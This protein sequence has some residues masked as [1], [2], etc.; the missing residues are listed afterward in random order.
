VAVFNDDSHAHFV[1]ILS[2]ESS[3]LDSPDIREDAADVIEGDGGIHGDFYAGRRP[4]VLQGTIIANSAEQRNERVEK[5]RRASRALRGNGT[6]EWEPQGGPSGGVLITVRRQQPLRITKGYVKDFSLPLVAADPRIYGDP[7]TKTET[8]S[9]PASS[10]K[11][12]GTLAETGGGAAWTNINNSKASDNTYATNAGTGET[13]TVNATNF[14]FAIPEGSVISGVKL[15]IERST[16]LEGGAADEFV[17]I[18]RTGATGE[19]KAIAGFWPTADAYA[20][21]GG[22]MDM[23]GISLT[24]AQ[25]NE[26][27]FGATM[28]HQLSG[29]GSTAR[30]D[31]IRITVYYNYNGHKFSVTN[32]GDADS[33][34]ILKLYGPTTNPTVKNITT[35]ESI[36]LTYTLAEG[37]YIEID[38]SKITAKLN[39]VTDVSY[40]VTFPADWW[41]LDPG[42]NELEFPS[43]TKG[44][45]IYKAAW[46]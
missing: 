12:V 34:P 44:I 21:Y 16:T 25:V 32:S 35:G 14:G 6:L 22:Q 17:K 45:V 31:H 29:G 8:Y 39:G 27:A 24:P 1:G 30:I 20:V 11:S 42:A 36:S 41:M 37:D 40:A 9:A 10:L 5:L 33:P 38:M 4:V 26:S 18:I 28:R 7:A 13:K 23:H 19:N 2:P 15:E 3:G 43:G 46:M